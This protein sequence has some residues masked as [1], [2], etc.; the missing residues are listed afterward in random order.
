MGLGCK[1][2]RRKAACKGGVPQT[3]PI[4]VGS[5]TVLPCRHGDS[6]GLVMWKDHPT[7][8]V[9]RVLDLDQR[10]WWVNDT[11]T[12]LACS[13]ELISSEDATI[14]ELGK[15]DTCVC[16]CRTGLVP[17]RMALPAHDYV[18]ARAGEDSEGDL[19]CHRSG[20]QPECLL[21]AQERIAALLEVVHRRVFAVFVVPNGGSGD[22]CAHLW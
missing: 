10:G 16:C 14:P 21:L 4:K 7:C 2:V 15:L 5:E 18:V 17:D 8:P 20:R 13:E 3:C 22:G 1:H 19:V 6:L 9:V 11:S 12:W